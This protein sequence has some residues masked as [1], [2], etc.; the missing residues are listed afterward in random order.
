T[1]SDYDNWLPAANV[2]WNVTENAVVRAGLS[3]T[4]TRANPTDLLLGLNIRNADVSQVSLGN[5][6]L[7][8]YLSDNIDLG[9]EYYTG[10]EGY[11]GVAAFRKG[12]NGFTVRQSRNVT[13]GDLAQ[14]GIT[15]DS[16]SQQQKDAVN[17]RG[18][19]DAFVELQ[20]TVNAS[21]RLTIDG[22]EFNW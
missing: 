15:M 1:K 14:Y 22:L 12:I 11:F 13:F 3:Q 6:D 19:N 10:Q 16:L 7:E 4:M 5:P 18:G 2:A 8:P 17:G 21:G 9:F 20:Q